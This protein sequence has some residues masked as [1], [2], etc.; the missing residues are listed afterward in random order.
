VQYGAEIRWENIEGC[1]EQFFKAMRGRY[2]EARSR[3]AM[4]EAVFSKLH[5]E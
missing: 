4:L 3:S 5:G 2:V 1:R